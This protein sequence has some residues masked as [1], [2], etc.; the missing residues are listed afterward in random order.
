M[1]GP[2]EPALELSGVH[3][4]FGAREAIRG[5]DL[6]C[7]RGETV[8]LLGS[9]GCGKS[10]VLRLCL[11]L[12]APDAGSVRV[13]GE[14]VVPHDAL[15]LRRRMGYVIQDGGLFPHLTA[16]ANV[17]LAGRHFGVPRAALA[18]RVRLLAALVRLPEP[19]LAR[20]PLQLSGGE[21][22]RV[23]LMRALALDPELLL[24][25]EPF[26]ALDPLVRAELQAELRDIVRRL[27]KSV[28]LVTHD[29]AEAGFLSDH[30]ALMRDG[31][32]LQE[33]SLRDLLERPVDP[34]V[35]RFLR[36][37]R[38]VTAEAAD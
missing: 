26:A 37:Q 36:A 9:S 5:L 17:T 24:L 38:V 6:R 14:P 8:A 1:P 10:T 23:A 16:E 21:R 22:Q 15:G 7:A 2:P 33:G 18:E 28:L 20:H 29:V 34:Y 35:T 3:K 11:G 25:D 30:I 31:A 13:E 27:G 19:L 12:V 4:R 32:V